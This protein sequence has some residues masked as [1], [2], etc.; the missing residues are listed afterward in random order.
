MHNSLYYAEI[1]YL[2]RFL[3]AKYMEGVSAVGFTHHT[4]PLFAFI[5]AELHKSGWPGDG[6]KEMSNFFAVT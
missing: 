5:R 6:S 2:S 1:C 3:F 4:K